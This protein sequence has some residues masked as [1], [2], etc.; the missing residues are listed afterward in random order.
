V[1]FGASGI[2]EGRNDVAEREKTAVDGNTLLDALT[3]GSRAFELTS[4]RQH[5]KRRGEREK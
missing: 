3:G 1:R 2:T 5:P 4:D